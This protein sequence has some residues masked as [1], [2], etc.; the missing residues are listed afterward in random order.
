[1]SKF[2]SLLTDDERKHIIQEAALSRVKVGSVADQISH[3]TEAAVLVKLAAQVD[4]VAELERTLQAYEAHGVTCQTFRHFVDSPCAECNVVQPEAPAQAV[5]QVP[6]TDTQ[7]RGIAHAGADWLENFKVNGPP[8]RSE[9][10]ARA[11]FVA[12]LAAA[13]AQLNGLGAGR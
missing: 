6:L 4:R 3:A 2:K 9:P 7:L 5:V 1:M 13:L 8:F 12:A 10:E 11:K